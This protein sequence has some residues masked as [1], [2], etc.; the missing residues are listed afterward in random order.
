MGVSSSQWVQRTALWPK[1]VDT[2]FAHAGCAEG[3]V[4]EDCSDVGGYF[5][6]WGTPVAQYTCLVK[7]LLDCSCNGR[8]EMSHECSLWSSVYPFATLS[9]ILKVSMFSFMAFWNELLHI[10]RYFWRLHRL[11]KVNYNKTLHTHKHTDTNTHLMYI[12]P[13]CASLSFPL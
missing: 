4:W 2:W 1:A 11:L 5:K 6:R 7:Y 9:I 12:H 8:H 3:K 10:E 13:S